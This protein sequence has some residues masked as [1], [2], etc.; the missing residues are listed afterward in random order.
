MVFE[1]ELISIVETK[2]CLIKYPNTCFNEFLGVW[3][4][5]YA[6]MN[7]KNQ[8][9]SNSL[10]LDII[11]MQHVFFISLPLIIL[12]RYDQLTPSGSPVDV[13]FKYILIVHIV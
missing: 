13:K 12:C 11:L 6:L 8:K 9:R 2:E 7:Q 10:F 1:F 5:L 3:V 4:T